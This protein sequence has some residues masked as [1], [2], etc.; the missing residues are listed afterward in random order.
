M[1]FIVPAQA[2]LAA[3][4]AYCDHSAVDGEHVAHVQAD[5][6]NVAE[7][8]VQDEPSLLSLQECAFCHLGTA[9]PAPSM[10]ELAPKERAHTLPGHALTRYYPS[11]LDRIERVPLARPDSA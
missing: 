11:H 8:G 5:S 1:L 6:A 7:D 9:T 3:M 10:I 4:C 2:A